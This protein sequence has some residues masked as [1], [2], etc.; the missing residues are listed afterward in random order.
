MKKTIQI[1]TVIFGALTTASFII[2]V[3]KE[4]LP[5]KEYEI[6]N[7]FSI[8]NLLKENIIFILFIGFSLIFIGFLTFQLFKSSKSRPILQNGRRKRIIALFTI[9][10]FLGVIILA[11]IFLSIYSTKEFS[12]YYFNKILTQKETELAAKNI[13]DLK[14]ISLTVYDKYDFELGTTKPW[15]KYPTTKEYENFEISKEE[16]NSGKNSLK[17]S[18]SIKATDEEDDHFAIGTETNILDLKGISAKIFIP[19]TEHVIEKELLAHFVIYKDIRYKP[20][21]Y[22][23][24]GELQLQINGSDFLLIPGEW[25]TIFSELNSSL[26]LWEKKNNE[27]FEINSI[28]NY[29]N[30]SITYIYITVRCANENYSG[31]VYF[32][33]IYLFK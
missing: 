9:F 14:E 23:D 12:Q 11:T 5:D 8:L 7:S 20:E 17:L 3:Y 27:W 2:T 26:V 16:S 19:N 6:L 30:D 24:R 29:K 13:E 31:E 32:D 15:K 10:F 25:T 1:L 18:G 28:G 33:D 22:K 4:L 21:K